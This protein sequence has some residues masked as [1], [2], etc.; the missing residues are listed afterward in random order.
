M[1]EII[2]EAVTSETESITGDGA[3]ELKD[4]MA[5]AD[6]KGDFE[7]MIRGEYKAEFDERVKRI[8]DKRFRETKTLKEQA[9][10]LR[11]IVDHLSE[12][13]GESDWDKLYERMVTDG[14]GSPNEE[15]ERL[16]AENRALYRE[17]RARETVDQWTKGAQALKEQNPDFDLSKEMGN[18]RFQ[19]LLRAGVDVKDAYR[20]VHADEIMKN[21]VRYAAEKTMEKTISDIRTRG[22]RP[23][24]NGAGGRGAAR[25]TP[26]SV[27]NMTRR[28]REEIE[29]RCARGEKVYF[30]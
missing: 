11:P 25:I 1:E 28:E 23:E 13:Y 8:I 9:A 20:V 16:K 26:V 6:K 14:G 24:E 27:R 4:T 19:S 30:D 15:T 7:R 21:A 22:M 12:K 17:K 3:Q 18:S 2:V 5:E 29:R 10:K